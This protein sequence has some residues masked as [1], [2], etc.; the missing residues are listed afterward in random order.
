MEARKNLPIRLVACS[1]PESGHLPEMWH[2]SMPTCHTT[3]VNKRYFVCD[4]GRKNAPI[5]R[6]M[7]IENT[8]PP[9][10]AQSRYRTLLEISGLISRQP[11]L[12]IALGSLRRLMSSV[13]DFDSIS[14]LLLDA[15]EKLVRLEV[16][17]RD[18][19]VPEFK[20]G[21]QLSVAGTA[22]GHCIETQK[23]VFVPDAIDELCKIPELGKVSSAGIHSL[24]IIP[25]STQRK[26]LGAL[27][28][29][30]KEQEFRQSDLELM[31]SVSAHV[32]ITLE[33]AAAL[34]KAAEYQHQLAKE[35]DRLTDSCLRSTTM[36]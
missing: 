35:R 25:V 5:S 10:V 6:L 36:L 32:A 22:F 26:K 31:M 34:D 12:E 7:P 29:A 4:S 13:A 20:I 23:S 14:L 17:D 27:V 15:T 30:T 9:D 21:V 11:N 3:P 16:F 18:A 8:V 28:F 1:L 19:D 33:S 2:F 24:Y